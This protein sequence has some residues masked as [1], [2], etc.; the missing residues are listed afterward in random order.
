VIDMQDPWH[1]E[2]YRDK[3]RSQRPP[4]YW[5]SY[6]LN[7]Y[8]EPIAMKRVDGLIAVSDKYIIDLKNRYKEIKEVASVTIPFGAFSPDLEIAGRNH[9][10]FKTLLNPGYTNVVYVGRGGADMHKATSI[11]FEAIK[12]GIANEPA[13]FK[14]LRFY[15]IGTSYAPSGAG[16]ETI[17]PLA[18][19]F[20]VE[21]NV[22]ELTDRIS[23]YHT[24]ATLQNA[25]TLFIPGS[26]DP[27]YSASKI[28][29]YLLCQKP[30]IAIFNRSSNVVNVLNNCTENATVFTFGDNAPPAT[31]ALYCLLADTAKGIRSPL[32]LLENF[33]DY[34]ARNLTYKQC[35]L[36]NKVSFDK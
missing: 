10:H 12:T 20:G 28:Y 32:K 21:N 6:R 1:S 5:F 30:L 8:L 22:I 23:F 13:I 17:M 19:E 24:L 33:S 15:F 35:K 18:R 31:E 7:K 36:F 16:R 25:D 11:L 9:S 34:S 14:T 2:Y 4:K 3:P 29:P 26:D 27:G